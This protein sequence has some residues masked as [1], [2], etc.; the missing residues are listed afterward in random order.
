MF[1]VADMSGP[2]GQMSSMPLNLLP[3]GPLMAL[4]HLGAAVALAGWLRAG[5]RLLWRVAGRVAVAVL[6]TV[7]AALDFDCG[8]PNPH[9]RWAAPARTDGSVL[10]HRLLI[11]T[12]QRRGPPLALSA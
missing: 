8:W 4:S 12:L 10:R 11:H 5:E 2:T 9:L 1:A 7:R 3:G 6:R